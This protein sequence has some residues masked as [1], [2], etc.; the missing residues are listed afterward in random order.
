MKHLKTS[1]RD[2]R[3]LFERNISVRYLAEPLTSFDA[4]AQATTIYAFMK[5]HDYDVIGVRRY[6]LVVGYANKSNLMDGTLANHLIEFLPSDIADDETPLIE[7]FRLMRHSSRLF[8]RVLGRVGG[9]ITRGDLQKA[10]VRM[11]LFGLISLIE[12]QLLRIIREGYPN[13]A[14]KQ[15][16]SPERLASAQKVLADRQRRNEAIDLADCLQFCDRR[17]IVLESNELRA[18]LGFDSRQSGERSL[19]DLEKS[20]NNLAHSQDII[21]GY[22]PK[23]VDLAEIA[24]RLLQRCEEAE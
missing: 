15:I 6:G 8:I 3:D 7:V 23:I 4:E 22:W 12:M 24:E 14:W 5:E 16:L 17:D 1:F 20:R 10:P 18:T 11:W 19:K 13:D 9:I 21:T 2:L